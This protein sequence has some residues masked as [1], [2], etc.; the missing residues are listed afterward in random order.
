LL[1]IINLGIFFQDGTLSDRI[2]SIIA[3]TIAFIAYIPTIEQ[4]IPPSANIVLT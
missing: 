2:A 4:T 3:L 1:G